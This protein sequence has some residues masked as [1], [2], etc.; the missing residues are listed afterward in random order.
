MSD[1]LSIAICQMKVAERK[2]DNLKAAAQM[3][4]TAASQGAEMV[5]LPEMF[6]TPYEN[7]RMIQYAE[8]VLGSSYQM[9]SQ[10]AGENQV[11]LVGGSIPERE[12][13]QVYNT[14][15]IFDETGS[16]IG[17][18]RKMHL[19]DID[20]PGK[21]SVK[22]SAD[23]S[24]GNHL[25]VIEHRGLTFGV[26]ICYDCRFPEVSRLIAL[27]GAQL[28]IIPAEFGLTTGQAHW[29]LLMKS[30]AVDNQL[31]VIGASA[32]RNS[33]LPYQS[34]GHSM[35]VDPWGEILCEGTE[36]ETILYANLDLDR[37]DQIRNELP[38]LRHR[39]TD[40]Y[41]LNLTQLK[42]DTPQ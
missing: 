13:P 21:I 1:K 17:K 27:Q 4:K 34:W 6:N 16:L 26:I 23:I 42:E 36:T 30:R 5:I 41:Q 40:L 7:E 22:E 18:Y 19:F 35:V 10:S 32:A 38:L 28:L 11:L 15:Y 8:P 29:E 31:F 33:D 25:T 3:I 9:L 12:G 37:I 39:R 14:C 20:I 2:E 24:A